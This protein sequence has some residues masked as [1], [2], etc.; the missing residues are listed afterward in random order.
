MKKLLSTNIPDTIRV[1]LLN[2]LSKSLFNTN[3]DTSVIIAA[4]SKA[5]A[6]RI[7]YKPGLALAYKN[8][9]IG[10]YLEGK[11]KEAVLTWQQAIDVY[12]LT[13]DK[14]GVANMLSNQGAVYF[15]QGDD[16]KAFELY[17]Q[18]L[19]MSE[20]LNDT[21]RILTSLTNIGGVYSNK[22]A[23]YQKALEYFLRSYKLSLAINDQYSIGTSA[24]NVGEIY[25]KMG[26]DSTALNYFYQS[27]KAYRGTENLPYTLNDIGRI[28]THQEKFDQAIKI[29]TE[30]YEYSKKLDT[31]LDQI[32]SL[33]GLAQAYYAKG[34]IGAS[35]N[36]YKQSLDV[37]IPMN[38]VTEIKDAYQGLSAAYSKNAD[39][40][41]AFK[42]QDLLLAIKD[43]IYNT[44]TDKKLGTLQFTFDLEK[45]ESQINLLNKDN[46]IK[47]Q[48]IKRQKLV[49]YG[50]IGGFA[51]VC[52]FAAVFLKQRNRIG[53]EKKR[54]EE[55]LLNILPEETAEELKATGT[56]K[57]KSLQSVSV[58]FT[59][60][61]N[62]T[63]A[64]EKLTPEELV[65]E[66]NHCYSEFDRIITRYGI[67]KIKTI[68]DSYM[69]AGGLPVSNDTHPFDVVSAGLEMVKFIEENKRERQRKGQ[70]Y[71]ELRL[72]IHSGPVVA[73]IVGIKK[74]AY[75]IWGDTVNTASR[76]ES[77]GEVGR[78]NISGSTYE[79]VKD[80]FT[81]IHRGKIEA[82]NKGFIDMYFVEGRSQA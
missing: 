49:K 79:L 15:A 33:V 25:Y 41:N 61:K 16:A 5:I 64:S 13:G 71:F 62:F 39:Y 55:L 58:L 81:C 51:V 10:Y 54:S 66:I 1:N 80:K 20:A 68:G 45:K 75:D 4:S 9:G 59:D 50:F 2:A 46:E 53:K 12:K 65:A 38:T 74:F 31:K 23:T 52:L 42:Y 78:V 60:F 18:S 44:T 47:Q 82:K 7:N 32:Q 21:L 77:S 37:S 28:Y 19:K 27:E 40:V 57:T 3:P 35:I 36:A 30:A 22:E 26:D 72:G 34:D 43:T 29:H 63:L 70:P 48:E 14:A 6:E 11:Y 73:G 8:M 17:L 69:C 24:V 56:A 67:E 76:M